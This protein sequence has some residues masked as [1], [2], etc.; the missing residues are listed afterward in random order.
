MFTGWRVFVRA[1][2]RSIRTCPSHRNASADSANQLRYFYEHE[3]EIDR[4]VDMVAGF[5]SPEFIDDDNAPSK[6]IIGEIREY[7]EYKKSA[8]PIV[9]DTIGLP[10][11]RNR[12]K[13]FGE[14]LAT[15]EALEG[16]P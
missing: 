8:G 1:H 6:R 12:C 16:G 4:L 13:H 3:D 10:T 15:L 7:V 11:L 2:S 5:D 14:W 9:A